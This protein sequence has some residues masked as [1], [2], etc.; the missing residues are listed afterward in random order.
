MVDQTLGHYSRKIGSTTSW[1]L[2]W[3]SPQCLVILMAVRTWESAS[4]IKESRT[5]DWMIWTLSSCQYLGLSLK[6]LI[7]ICLIRFLTLFRKDS[8]GIWFICMSLVYLLIGKWGSLL[9]TD[10]LESFC[11]NLE[12]KG[13]LF[14]LLQEI[15]VLMSLVLL[16]NR[17]WFE[18]RSK[19]RVFRW[20]NEWKWVW[21]GSWCVF[22]MRRG[23][24]C[25]F[26][27]FVQKERYFV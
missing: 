21:F 6:D 20:K 27:M 16:I 1:V 19:A 3:F 17:F 23:N 15:R 4:W 25:V 26:V 14:G 12:G 2:G 24:S 5:G 18:E 7:E 10:N 22:W 9:W 13:L 11:R 8:S